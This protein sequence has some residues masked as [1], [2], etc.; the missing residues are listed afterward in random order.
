MLLAGE[1][2]PTKGAQVEVPLALGAGMHPDI[3][4]AL[5][6]DQHIVPLRPIELS[7][8][9]AIVLLAGF[10]AHG[11]P[12]P[13]QDPGYRRVPDD[14][15]PAAAAPP[16]AFKPVVELDFQALAQLGV[17]FWER[18][19]SR[20]IGAEVLEIPLS[21]RDGFSVAGSNHLGRSPPHINSQVGHLQKPLA[22]MPF[23]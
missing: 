8:D 11:Q 10:S 1:Q 19:P 18:G 5:I 17:N 3:A 9:T 21:H 13:H 16:V 4:A 14:E 23:G 7:P 20:L 6:V 22:L 12:V 15:H 2:V